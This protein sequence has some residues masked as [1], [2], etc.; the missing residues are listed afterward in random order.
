MSLQTRNNIILGDAYLILL[1]AMLC[2]L[3]LYLSLDRAPFLP[4]KLAIFLASL[5]GGICL[6]STIAFIPILWLVDEYLP[7]RRYE[8]CHPS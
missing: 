7:V 8:K 6:L 1:S 4:V 2:M 3:I 5:F